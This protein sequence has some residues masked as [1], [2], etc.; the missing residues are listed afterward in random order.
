MN[1]AQAVLH[2][3]ALPVAPA[4]RRRWGLRETLLVALAIA[5]PFHY[6]TGTAGTVIDASLGDIVVAVVCLGFCVSL[7]WDRIAFPRYLAPTV[8]FM[9]VG[10]ASLLVPLAGPEKAPAYF[11]PLAGVLEVVRVGGNAAWMLAVYTLLR[12]APIAGLRVFAPV[13]VLAASIFSITTIRESLMAWGVRPGGPFPNENLYADYL[14]FN[15]FLSVMLARLDERDGK[16]SG[17][18]IPFLL[19]TPLL[20]VGI[21]A[22]GS[23]GAILG[24][25][26]A[27]PVL[28]TWRRPAVRS[29]RRL[30]PAL[31]ALG[32]TGCGAVAYW[33]ANPFIA[34]R[35]STI[36][37]GQGPN[38]EDREY[39]RAMAIEA[40]S[41]SPV[42]GIGYGQFPGYAET[43][44]GWRRQPVHDTYLSI[45]AEVGVVGLAAFAWLFGLV[46]RDAVALG[47]GPAAA[48]SR[49]LLAIILAV[50]GQSLVSNGEHY[51]SM[52][53]AMGM[54]AGVYDAA[55][56]GEG[57]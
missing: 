52:W 25:A 27:F 10:L 33:H 42:L 39:L 15:V 46:I 8:G 11:N 9:L 29:W 45:A 26:V 23:R 34:G 2:A 31:V 13:S 7:L 36:V 5:Y 17:L 57:G 6:D 4:A 14:A 28:L 41:T 40:F 35:V 48:V 37:S 19:T 24:A 54:L 56:R 12:R 47:R 3:R 44:H 51:R 1:A 50:L 32:L 49:P 53:I 38:I 20:L 21:L 22:T 30:I 16:P 43:V 55:G 18:R